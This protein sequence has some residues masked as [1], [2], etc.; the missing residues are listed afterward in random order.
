MNLKWI[1][2][3]VTSIELTRSLILLEPS[4][5]RLISH[6]LTVTQPFFF[7]KAIKS[8]LRKLKEFAKQKKTSN[9]ISV[10]A[11]DGGGIKGLVIVQ[12]VPLTLENPSSF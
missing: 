3:V 1:R 8:V 5:S 9:V 6:F 11:L 10:L 2:I 4:P 7:Q 12:V